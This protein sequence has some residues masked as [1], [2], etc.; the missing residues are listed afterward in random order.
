MI[1]ESGDVSVLRWVNYLTV[2]RAHHVC[3][4]GVFVQLLTLLS[5]IRVHI[6]YLAN[7]LHDESAFWNVFAGSQTPAFVAGF[8]WVDIRVLV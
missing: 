6:E 1:N 8:E 2:I 4:S 3:T 7:I 5:N